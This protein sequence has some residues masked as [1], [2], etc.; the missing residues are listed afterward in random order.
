MTDAPEPY[1]VL[2]VCTGNT[3]RSPLA[4]ALA[5]RELARR[6]WSHVVVSS[7]GTAAWD[8]APASDGSLRAGAARGLDLTD[9]RSRALTP[10]L[11]DEAD[12]V[13]TMSGSHVARVVALGGADKVDLLT[14]FAGGSEAG[15]P[16]PFGGDDTVY[17]DTARVLEALVAGALDRLSSVLDP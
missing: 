13:L 15:V 6:Q 14:S 8:G 9:H 1:R 7:A 5:R 3:C 12:V 4:E 17:A 2:F 10:A 11:V 16:D